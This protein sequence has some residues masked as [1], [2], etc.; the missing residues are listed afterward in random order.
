MASNVDRIEGSLMSLRM[1]LGLRYRS[2]CHSV[3]ILMVRVG[4]ISKE[5]FFCVPST[6]SG[7]IEA[8]AKE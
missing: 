1:V 7:E 2:R 8:T 5:A 3:F 6:K 4:F